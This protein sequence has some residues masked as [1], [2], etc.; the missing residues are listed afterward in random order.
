MVSNDLVECYWYEYSD[1]NRTMQYIRFK[2]TIQRI[3]VD[4]TVKR[5]LALKNVMD[6]LYHSFTD[7]VRKIIDYKYLNGHDV[8]TWQDVQKHFNI[9]ASSCDRIKMFVMQRTA[10]A[11]GILIF[12]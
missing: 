6:S 11:L 12:K 3:E 9:S 1:I 10:E 2:A 5:L 4:K 8:Y 7:E